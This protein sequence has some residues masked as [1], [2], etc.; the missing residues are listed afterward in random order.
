MVTLAQ[1]QAELEQAAAEN[2][3]LK[4]ELLESREREAKR[5]REDEET[6]RRIANLEAEVEKQ[7]AWPARRGP[8]QRPRR[9]TLPKPGPTPDARS[10]RCGTQS[11]ARRSAPR[12]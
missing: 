8:K 10:T 1:T 7:R 2:A 12:R 3:K 4:A 9:E 11:R 5:H 6:A